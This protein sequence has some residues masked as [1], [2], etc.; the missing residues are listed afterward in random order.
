MQI[1]LSSPVHA[2]PA[3]ALAQSN[4][5]KKKFTKLDCCKE[6]IQGKNFQAD[7]NTALLRA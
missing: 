7:I 2:N 5:F 3:Y 6:S 1:V 4:N